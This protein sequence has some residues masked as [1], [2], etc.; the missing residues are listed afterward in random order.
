[1][2]KGSEIAEKRFPGFGNGCRIQRGKEADEDVAASSGR[3]DAAFSSLREFAWTN[4]EVPS[5]WAPLE[6][7]ALSLKQVA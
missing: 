5:R 6:V 7:V 1:V 2:K 4:Y 3:L